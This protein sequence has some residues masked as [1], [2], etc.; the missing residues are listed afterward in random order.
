MSLFCVACYVFMYFVPHIACLI[1]V[2]GSRLEFNRWTT[3]QLKCKTV[4]QS[5][6]EKEN[7]EILHKDQLSRDKMLNHWLNFY[8]VYSILVFVVF[9]VKWLYNIPGFCMV[10][11]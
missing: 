1:Q 11:A 6:A 4:T 5:E 2:S 8:I 10:S 7:P 3:I 9:Q